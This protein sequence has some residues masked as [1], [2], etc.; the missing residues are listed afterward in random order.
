ML[1]Q[2]TACD[3]C[4]PSSAFGCSHCVRDES[5]PADYTR[6]ASGERD[7]RLALLHTIR[8][9]LPRS[10]GALPLVI[11]LSLVIVPH[12]LQEIIQLQLLLVAIGVLKLLKTGRG[13]ERRHA[14][15]G[16]RTS[17]SCRGH[18]ELIDRLRR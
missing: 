7:P 16:I 5:S 12:G 8:L 10:L 6:S 15:A 2:L 3:S 1:G 13:G 11:I 4:H 17:A 18:A 14:V 9:I